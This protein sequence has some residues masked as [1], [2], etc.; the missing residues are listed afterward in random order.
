MVVLVAGL[1]FA[2]YVAMR[3]LGPQ[4]GVITM[5]T[6]R[7]ARMVNGDYIGVGPP[8]QG[9][10]RGSPSH[11]GGRHR[12]VMDDHARADERGSCRLLPAPS[13]ALAMPFGMAAI[14]AVFATV[15]LPRRR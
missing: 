12:C 6:A 3:V 13:R 15:W 11:A 1:S 8:R 9:F 4:G 14:L 2:G 5:G 10:A 7:R